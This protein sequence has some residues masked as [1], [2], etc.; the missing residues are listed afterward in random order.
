MSDSVPRI[1]L[2]R[3]VVVPVQSVTTVPS[4]IK[5]SDGTV[6]HITPQ[7]LEVRRI[8]DRKDDQGNPIFMVGN[9]NAVVLV[10]K[11]ESN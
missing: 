9:R 7:I 8:T 11:G 6:P 2:Q 1:N 10:K 5:L 4:I 3:T